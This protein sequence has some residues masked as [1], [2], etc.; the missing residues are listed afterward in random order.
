MFSKSILEVVYINPYAEKQEPFLADIIWKFSGFP[1]LWLSPK[2]PDAKTDKSGLF[3]YFTT[4]IT[5]VFAA[6]EITSRNLLY[7]GP[8]DINQV[9]PI[10]LAL[11]KGSTLSICNKQLQNKDSLLKSIQ[12]YI[13]ASKLESLELQIV[14]TEKMTDQYDQIFLQNPSKSLNLEKITHLLQPLGELIIHTTILPVEVEKTL[15]LFLKKNREIKVSISK[16][17]IGEASKSGIYFDPENC[18]WGPA[19]I[20]KLVKNIL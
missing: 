5:A 11:P 13:P 8:S 15:L 14:D 16:Y 18:D 4:E 7:I 20:S 17:P 2:F 6:K 9:L 1:E 12:E 19:F 3:H 10:I